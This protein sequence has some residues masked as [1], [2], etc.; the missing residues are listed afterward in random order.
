VTDPLELIDDNG[1]FVCGQANPVGLRLRF[2]AD[3]GRATT[4][5]TLDRRYQ[6][7]AGIAHGG[8]VAALLD[9]AMAY[10]AISLGRWAATAEMTVRYLRPVPMGEPLLL[11]AHVTRDTARLAECAAEL[12]DR[13]G[14]PLARATAKLVKGAALSPEERARRMGRGTTG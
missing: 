12:R 2:A 6:G 11:V 1:C 3:S 5:L 10:A 8:V 4:T 7:Y 14:Q 13:A 9:E